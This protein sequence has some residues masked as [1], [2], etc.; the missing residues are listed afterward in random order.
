M[1]DAFAIGIPVLAVHVCAWWNH[2]GISDLKTGVKAE[3]AALRAE[4]KSNFIRLESK[5]DQVSD[6]MKQFCQTMGKA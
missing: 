6:A 5:L 2:H 1:H 4:S 3:V